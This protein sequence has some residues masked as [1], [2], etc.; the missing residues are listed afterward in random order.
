MS[1]TQSIWN[2]V[3]SVTDILVSGSIKSCIMHYV[4][5]DITN[6]CIL[7]YMINIE[8]FDRR[9]CG[10]KL[11]ISNS[12]ETGKNDTILQ[13]LPSLHYN[14]AMC[15][16]IIDPIKYANCTIEWKFKIYPLSRK[17]SF[18]FTI[19]IVEDN[20]KI[21][22]NLNSNC[23]EPNDA[24]K[25]YAY[26]GYD[27]HCCELQKSWKSLKDSNKFVL[28]CNYLV[29]T[30]RNYGSHGAYL[31]E[32]R[33]KPWGKDAYVIKT[34]LNIPNKSFVADVNGESIY[35]FGCFNWSID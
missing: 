22:H 27:I 18:L 20:E 17:T 5:M 13:Q 33:I 14:S 28:L 11:I 8:K 35:G 19:G 24:S 32:S 6:L 30:P 2:A 34:I 10:Q 26:Y 3:D 23:F 12:Y 15:A 7:F 21:Q 4:P 25:N 16:F 29:N 9:L 1:S 31:E